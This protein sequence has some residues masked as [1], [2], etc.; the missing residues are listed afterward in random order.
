MHA[1]RQCCAF[2]T[3]RNS[4]AITGIKHSASENTSETSRT[5][6]PTRESGPKNHAIAATTAFARVV[7][8]NNRLAYI[9]IKMR[10]P[11]SAPYAHPTGTIPKEP[12]TAI[13][14]ASC[15]HDHDAAK[16]ALSS[17]VAAFCAA[18]MSNE[19]P[20]NTTGISAKTQAIGKK[21]TH[22]TTGTR[23]KAIKTSNTHKHT[24][25]PIKVCTKKSAAVRNTRAIILM[26]ASSSCNNDVSG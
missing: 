26:R 16:T 22:A 8:V 14:P 12:H 15:T 5:G 19:T 2:A 6:T 23:D 7:N 13:G 1:P 17:L 10:M 20:L 11:N 25:M 9:R 21:G 3:M 24:S 18:Y 4:C